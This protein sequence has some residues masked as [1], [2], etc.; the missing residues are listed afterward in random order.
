MS[1][2]KIY[3]AYIVAMWLT[4]IRKVLLEIDPKVWYSYTFYV[5][6]ET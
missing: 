5:T 3:V 1:Y 6:G 4:C 2:E